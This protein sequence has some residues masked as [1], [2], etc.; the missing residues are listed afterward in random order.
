MPHGLASCGHVDLSGPCDAPCG[1]VCPAS[2]I[3]SRL[4]ALQFPFVLS[5]AQRSRST[6]SLPIGGGQGGGA[7]S[8]PSSEPASPTQRRLRPAGELLSFASPKESNQ[9]KGD[10]GSPLCALRKVPCAAHVG[11]RTSQT[12]CAQTAK[13]DS[14][15]RRCAARRLSRESASRH[16]VRI[17][18]QR[19]VILAQFE[20]TDPDTSTPSEKQQGLVLT[21]KALDEDREDEYEY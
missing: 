17:R 10:P 16:G 13:P 18:P 4:Q 21:G 6:H 20:T 2:A 11:G 7:A 5:V 19:T 3:P 14:P 9:R 1:M 12:R 15:R 8:D